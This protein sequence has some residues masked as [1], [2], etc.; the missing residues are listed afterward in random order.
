M[1]SELL[2][3]TVK[4]HSHPEEGIQTDFGNLEVFH[5]FIVLPGRDTVEV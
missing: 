5:H 1:I 2:H 4:S 3:N